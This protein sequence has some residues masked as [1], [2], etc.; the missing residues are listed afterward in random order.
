MNF[1]TISDTHVDGEGWEMPF[2]RQTLFAPKFFVLA[3]IVKMKTYNGVYMEENELEK[4]KD[5]SLFFLNI[6]S[7]RC[8]HDQLNAFIEGFSTK[9]LVIAL[10]DM[11]NR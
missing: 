6:R 7:L 8:H 5:A 11:V 10:W 1:N 2:L 9:P 4:V 3:L